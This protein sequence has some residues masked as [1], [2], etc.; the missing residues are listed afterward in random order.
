MN[1]LGDNYLDKYRYRPQPEVH[2]TN[3]YVDPKAAEWEWYLLSR[4]LV[5]HQRMNH[6]ALTCSNSHP[7]DDLQQANYSG[8]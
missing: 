6:L 2:D 7:A 8:T 3:K 1:H 4:F 5:I